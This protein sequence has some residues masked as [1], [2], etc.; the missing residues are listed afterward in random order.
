[1]F[2]D[3]SSLFKDI[4][5]GQSEDTLLVNSE[6]Q[7]PWVYNEDFNNIFAS[8]PCPP[9]RTATDVNDVNSFC[10]IFYLG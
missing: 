3:P 5:W 1:M 4:G 10:S 9:C 7:Y 2:S 6:L 8:L